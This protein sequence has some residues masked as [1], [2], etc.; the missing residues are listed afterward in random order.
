[1]P[2]RKARAVEGTL[3]QRSASLREAHCCQP[4]CGTTSEKARPDIV[5]GQKGKDSGP[6]GKYQRLSES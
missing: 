3:T 2:P 1:M 4:P 6:T 5:A